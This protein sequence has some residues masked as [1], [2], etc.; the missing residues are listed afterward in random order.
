MTI[1]QEV[2]IY[3]LYKDLLPEKDFKPVSELG[4]IQ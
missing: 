4:D 1:K 3:K 2:N